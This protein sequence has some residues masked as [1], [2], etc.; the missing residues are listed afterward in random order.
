MGREIFRLF[1]LIAFVAMTIAGADAADKLVP[2]GTDTLVIPSGSVATYRSFDRDNITAH[3][4]GRFTLTGTWYYGI[5]EDSGDWTAY[6]IVNEATRKTLPYW[7]NRPGNGHIDIDNEADFVRAVV[8]SAAIERLK[9]AKK[10]TLSGKIS[11]VAENYQASV[12]C[13]G[14]YYYVHFVSVATMN[15]AA[16][17]RTEAEFG[18]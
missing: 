4:T 18:C 15:V 14:P 12:V 5:D 10:G 13:D 8:P 9:K 1:S 11:I 2:L 16:L 17:D 6:M 7:K 3:F